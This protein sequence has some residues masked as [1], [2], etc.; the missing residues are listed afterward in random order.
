MKKVLLITL[1]LIVATVGYSQQ[2]YYDVTGI[3]GMGLRFWSSDSYKIHM[4]NTSEYQF[5]P[6][7]DYSIKTNMSSTAGRGWTWGTSG[8]TP[9]AALDNL[10]NLLTAN[11][12]RSQVSLS[13]GLSRE[14][15]A[16]ANGLFL[17]KGM[18]TTGGSSSGNLTSIQLIEKDWSG[19]HAL[20]F[21][22]YASKTQLSGSLAALGNTKYSNDVGTYS[23]G[24]GAIMFFA[25][26]G[27][28]AFYVSEQSTGKGTNVDWGMADMYIERGG[29]VGIGILDP[30]NKLE[31]NGTMRSKELILENDNWPDYVF[32]DGYELKSLEEVSAYI[33]A[34]GHLPNIPSAEEVASN[35]V[36]MMEMSA[37]LLEKVEELTLYTISQEE[38]IKELTAQNQQMKLQE[39]KLK[40]QEALIQSLIER[41]EQLEK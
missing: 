20:L 30:T 24:A 4:G 17:H 2:N 18:G 39:E 21:N 28:M 8:L 19:S 33:K 5:G 29:N 10:G 26:S 41:I 27:L 9:I 16:H 11:S 14:S 13:A 40:K 34:N 25:N 31:V 38:K 22:S 1:F 37:S 7:T 23:N 3:N 32:T 35:G 6:V 12:I 15:D 36:K